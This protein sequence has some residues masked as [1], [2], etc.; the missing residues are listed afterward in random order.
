MTRIRI[1]GA[2]EEIGASTV[3]ELL[4]ARGVDAT[5]RFVAVAV[6]GSVIRRSEWPSTV[7]AVGDNVEIVRPFSGG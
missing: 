2:D 3:A 1:N 6:N 5:A 7:L 4:L